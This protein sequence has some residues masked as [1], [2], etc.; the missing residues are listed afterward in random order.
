MTY[1]DLQ[2]MQYQGREEARKLGHTSIDLAAVEREIAR[3]DLLAQIDATVEAQAWGEASAAKRGRNPK[4]PY[5]P[6]VIYTVHP[7][8][9]LEVRRT[10]NP[11]RGEAYATRDEA[12]ARADAVISY[13]KEWLRKNLAEPRMRALREQYGLPREV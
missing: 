13:R 3:Q 2:W 5:V 4:F 10:S 8:P 7:N 6:V 12:V 1:A 9:K 11:T